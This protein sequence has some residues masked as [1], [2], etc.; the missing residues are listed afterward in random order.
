[1]EQNMKKLIAECSKTELDA[2][3][4]I[5]PH[6]Y[7]DWNIYLQESRECVCNI[8]KAII[9]DTHCIVVLHNKESSH[10][11]GGL[12]H[13]PFVHIVHAPTNDTWARDFAPLSVQTD[14]GKI[15]LHF[16]FNGWGSKFSYDLD[17]KLPLLLDT[18][19][20][21]A[22]KLEQKDFV[23]EGGSIDYNGAGVLLSTT[24]CLLNP[25]RNPHLNQKHIEYILQKELGV[26]KILWLKHGFLKGDDTDSHIDNLARFID[27]RTIVY[28]KCNDTHDEHYEELNLMEKELQMF[29]GLDGACFNLIPLPMCEP[30]YYNNERLPASYA[31]FLMLEKRILVPFYGSSKD[32]EALEIIQQAHSSYKVEGVDCRVLIR[33]HGSL[34]CMSMQFPKGTLNI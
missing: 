21:F 27:E 32:K 25:T 2:V 34:H 18:M 1:M 31:N 17:K 3:L 16:I 11:L 5:M 10:V 19:G 29:R 15:L 28:I 22:S 23:L 9:K 20:I 4:I 30:I 24:K 14:E 7:S 6:M 12:E 26:E 33:Q 8:I 13:N